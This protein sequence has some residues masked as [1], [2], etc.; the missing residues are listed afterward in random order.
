MKKSS[1]SSAN[2]LSAAVLALAFAVPLHALEP[3]ADTVVAVVN[4]TEITLGHMIATREALPEQYRQ[5]PDDVLFKGVLEQ[6]IQQTALAQVGEGQQTKRDK[7]MLD[8]QKRTYLAGAVLDTTAATAVSDEAL[9]KL[10]DETYVT[11]EPAKEYSA[12]HIL[13]ATEEEAKAIRAEIDGG[14]DFAVIAKEKSTDKGSAA[15]GGDLGWFG[16]GMMVKPFEDA[17]LAMESGKISAPVQSDF[18]WHIIKLNE[19]RTAAAPKL[20]DVKDALTGDIRQKAV[21]AKVKELTDAAKVEKTVDGI[22]PA[23][24]KNTALIEN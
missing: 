23:I 22:D 9:Q 5:L 21:E 6:I 8:N 3:T 16:L 18:G 7:L 12:A 11:A 20:E 24:L 13:V 17:V 10:Y 1:Y 4:G 19:V 15:N 2:F 14:G